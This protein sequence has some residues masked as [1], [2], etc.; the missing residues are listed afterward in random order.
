MNP[1]SRHLKDEVYELGGKFLDLLFPPRCVNCQKHIGALCSNCLA[2]VNPI[3]TPVCARCGSELNSPHESCSHCRSY[4]LQITQMRAA[5][6]HEGAVRE[7]IHALKYRRRRDTLAPLGSFLAG[8]LKQS[9]LSFDLLTSV[10]LYPRRQ[11]ERGF[12]QAEL[13]AQETARLTRSMY[14]PVLECTRATADQV[15]LDAKARYANVRG[16]YRV[17]GASVKGK[18]IVIIDD[19]CT[20]G[21]TFDACAQPLLESGARAVY[22]LAVARPHWNA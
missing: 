11:V 16:A 15:V 13:L 20:T 10:P 9:N 4:P 17:C 19:V 21:A 14:I 7:A 18:A 8:Y 12:N 1:Q 2:T 22:G 5:V 6:W 3:T